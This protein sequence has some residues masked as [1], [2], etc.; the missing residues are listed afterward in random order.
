MK[1]TD[2]DKNKEKTDIFK[3]AINSPSTSF[4]SE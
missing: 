2:G 1:E 4:Q 3:I